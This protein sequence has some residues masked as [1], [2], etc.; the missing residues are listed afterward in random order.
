MSDIKIKMTTKPDYNKMTVAVSIESPERDHI[1]MSKDIQSAEESY[2]AKR[3][4]SQ[5]AQDREC[6]D[7]ARAVCK[8]AGACGATL[9]AQ[10]VEHGQLQFV[11]GI[12]S[13]NQLK[14]FHENA[15]INISGS[16][17]TAEDFEQT[18]KKIQIKM[19]THPDYTNLTTVV[20]VPF[21][22]Q[23]HIIMAKDIGSAEE[24]YVA[25]RDEATGVQQKICY[26]RARAVCKWAGACGATLKAQRVQNG[27]LHLSFGFSSVELLKE[28]EE[29]A[30]VNIGSAT[31]TGEDFGQTSGLRR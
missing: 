4:E 6:Y 1:I 14:E 7:R 17:M 11:F 3:D 25:K 12:S 30:S 31:M 8:W 2:I 16:T 27:Q 26:D 28:F 5:I 24:S 9:K 21:L 22:E 10:R 13:L 23:D 29:G 19:I 20:S 18:E 15:N